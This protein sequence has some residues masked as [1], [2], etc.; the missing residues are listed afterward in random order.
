MSDWY[1]VDSGN[2]RRSVEAD[3]HVQAAVKATVEHIQDHGH[4]TPGIVYRVIKVGDADGDA[5]I[6]L[7]EL[8]RSEGGFVDT[9][10]P[11]NEGEPKT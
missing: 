6:M 7:S 5:M 1:G 3:N 11:L 4:A 8:V 9:P 2:V 10:D